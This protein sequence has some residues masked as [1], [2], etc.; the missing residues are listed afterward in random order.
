MADE[1]KEELSKENE[2]DRIIAEGTGNKPETEVKSEEENDSE[3]E[4][5]SEEDEEGA[6]ETDEEDSEKE[7]P[8]EVSDETKQAL[9]LFKAL[10]SDKGHEVVKNLAIRAGLIKEDEKVTNISSKKLT[11]LIAESL[12]EEWSFL[13]ER[14]GVPLERYVEEMR[15]ELKNDQIRLSTGLELEKAWS[16][17]DSETEGDI[18]KYQD[19][20]EELS[21]EYS[22]GRGVTIEK[23]LRG[24]YKMA[25]ADKKESRQIQKT[26]EK[27]NKNS[28]DRL[29]RSSEVANERV[30][31]GTQLPSLEQSIE[32]ALEEQLR[33]KRAS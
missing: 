23:Y 25:S 16:K 2:L 1:N 12:G 11:N 5:T 9:A 6:E 26:V 30:K 28:S 8:K 7:S 20:I 29:S 31:K 4:E 33:S 24:L 17:L 3:T 22:M 19:K 32:E 13:A 21:N 15:S 10:K 14:I 18:L 27:I